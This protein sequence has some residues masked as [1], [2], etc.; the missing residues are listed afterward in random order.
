VA[1]MTRWTAMAGVI[2]PVARV[3]ITELKQ[4]YPYEQ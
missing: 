2:L 4:Q 3:E 1:G